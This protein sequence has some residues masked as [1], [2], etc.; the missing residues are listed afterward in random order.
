MFLST[1]S[2]D[3]VS[4]VDSSESNESDESDESDEPRFVPKKTKHLFGAD[5]C[6]FGP[7]YW[8][9]S[10]EATHECNVSNLNG[11]TSAEFQLIYS[12]F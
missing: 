4:H 3:Q 12:I 8:C 10:P 1:F 11:V 5:K 2:E 7:S 9:S 6:S